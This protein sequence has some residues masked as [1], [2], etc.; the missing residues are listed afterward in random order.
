MAVQIKNAS[1]KPLNKMQL[2]KSS[3]EKDIAFYK[4]ANNKYWR[5][6]LE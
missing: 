3:M 5:V 1:Q 4:V 2:L 6:S